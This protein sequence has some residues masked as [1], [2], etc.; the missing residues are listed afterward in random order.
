MSEVHHFSYGLWTPLLAYIMSCTGALLGLLLT[1]RAR[2]ASGRSRALWLTF[3]ALSIGGTGIWVMHFI[4][5]LGF[6][7]PTATIR[8]NVPL[9]L[10]SALLAVVVVGGGLFTVGF[11]ESRLATLL[12]GGSL[13]GIGVAIIN[14]TGVGGVGA[15]PPH[16]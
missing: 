10:L 12:A 7:I 16:A 9:T 11:G 1:A 2:A 5:M 13:T 3:G 6:S 15:P 8:Y 14:Y 4:A